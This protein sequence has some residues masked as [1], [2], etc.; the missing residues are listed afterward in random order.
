MKLNLRKITDKLNILSRKLKNLSNDGSTFTD[1][2]ISKLTGSLGGYF[3]GRVG[4]GTTSP[5]NQLQVNHIG[6]DGNDGLMIVRADTSTNDT[7][8]LG[9]VGFDSTDGNVPSTITEASCYIAAYAAEDHD[10]GDKGGDLVFGTSLIDDDDDTTSHERIRISSEGVTSFGN[11]RHMFSADITLSYADD[12]PNSNITQ[13]PNLKIPRYSILTRI[14]AVTKQLSDLNPHTLNIRFSTVSGTER[15]ATLS[16]TVL[17][18]LGAANAGTDSSGST[19][20]SDIEIGAGSGVLKKVWINQ[21]LASVD[22]TGGDYY[23]Y[24]CNAVDNGT[25]APNT[26]GILS[27]TIEWIGID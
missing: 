3:A 22:L 12:T 23:V 9:G 24:V 10:T 6:F 2:T 15:H 25:I 7:D 11:G 14:S 17:E 26:A 8:L 13:I 19:S 18:L 1:L 4:I 16:G 20:T 27:V 5:V 21:T